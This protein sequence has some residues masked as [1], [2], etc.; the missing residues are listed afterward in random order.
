M[1]PNLLPAAWKM[2]KLKIYF[3][4]TLSVL[5]LVNYGFDSEI[6][7]GCDKMEEVFAPCTIPLES[8]KYSGSN[9][10]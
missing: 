9:Q 10:N 5:S 3:W 6:I 2:D 7:T 8:T 1:L 4:N